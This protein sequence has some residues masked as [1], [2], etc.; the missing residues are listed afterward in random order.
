M[1]I[2]ET[3]AC[4]CTMNRPRLIIYVTIGGNSIKFVVTVDLRE[5]KVNGIAITEKGLWHFLL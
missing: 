3:T 5:K 4:S 2:Q 1:Y